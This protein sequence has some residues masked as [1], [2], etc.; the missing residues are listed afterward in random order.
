LNI[1][2]VIKTWMVKLWSL[3][4]MQKSP[5]NNHSSCCQL[6]LYHASFGFHQR[7]ESGVHA[8]EVQQWPALSI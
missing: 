2:T 7:F 4:H 6:P 5:G 1:C 8:L 3:P